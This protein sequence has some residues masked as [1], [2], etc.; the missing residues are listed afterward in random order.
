[1]RYCHLDC[2]IVIEFA[3]GVVPDGNVVVVHG[4]GNASVLTAIVHHIRHPYHHSQYTVLHTDHTYRML[5]V[6]GL[7]G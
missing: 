1:M 3:T 6:Y 7:E 5:Y 4:V 2:Y